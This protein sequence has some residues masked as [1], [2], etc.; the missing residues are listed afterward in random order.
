M[1]VTR[2]SIKSG[3]NQQV[4]AWSRQATVDEG[5]AVFTSD[6]LSRLVQEHLKNYGDVP[7]RIT[8]DC[9]PAVPNEDKGL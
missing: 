4:L 2:C 6:I 9:E 8:T 3:D 1:S 5:K 7:P